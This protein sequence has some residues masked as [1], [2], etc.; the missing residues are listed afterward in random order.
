MTQQTQLQ[1][2]RDDLVEIGI[3][4]GWRKIESRTRRLTDVTQNNGSRTYWSDLGF[5]SEWIEAHNADL[6]EHWT[7]GTYVVQDRRDTVVKISVAMPIHPGII[8]ADKLTSDTQGE[9]AAAWGQFLRHFAPKLL[10]VATV[11]RDIDDAAARDIE[12]YFD[13]SGYPT[14]TFCALIPLHAAHLFKRTVDAMSEINTR[15]GSSHHEQLLAIS[16]VHWRYEPGFVPE[17][18]LSGAH[19]AL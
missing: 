6:N 19:S 4:P 14:G 17:Q 8:P 7:P 10:Q 2:A 18:V 5:T 11:L 16:R 9:Q 13:T 12:I 3:F 15:A 1:D